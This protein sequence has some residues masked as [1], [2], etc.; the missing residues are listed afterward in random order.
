[1]NTWRL[2]A[3][4]SFCVFSS[5]FILSC[6]HGDKSSSVSINSCNGNC[7]PN[8]VAAGDVDQTSVVLWAR[9][10]FTGMVQFEYVIDDD[11]LTDEEPDFQQPDGVEEKEVETVMDAD[12]NI[13][14]YIPTKVEL[15]GLLPRMPRKLFVE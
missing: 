11:P 14:D 8:G 3:L 6:H 1:M 12:G 9:A 10:V 13:T 4:L 5:L 2:L 7:F 15:T